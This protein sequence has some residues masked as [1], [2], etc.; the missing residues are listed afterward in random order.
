MSSKPANESAVP[1]AARRSLSLATRLTLWYASSAF[2]LVLVATLVLFWS[3]IRHL[4]H[5]DDQILLDRL[6]LLRTLAEADPLDED[7]LRAAVAATTSPLLGLPILVRVSTE[8]KVLAETHGLTDQIP[9]AELQPRLNQLLSTPSTTNGIEF[10]TSQGRA[11]RLLLLRVPRVTQPRELLLLAALDRT[12]EEQLVERYRWSLVLVV[13]LAFVVCGIVGHQIARRSIRPLRNIIATAGSIGSTTLHERIT[14]SPL[15]AELADLADTFNDMLRRLEESFDRLSRFSADIAH[16]LRTPLSNLRG[17][18]EVALTKPRSPDEYR[19]VL[20]SSLDECQRLSRMIDSLL[21][22]ARAEHPATQLRRERLDI[23]HE[24]RLIAE[25]HEAAATEAGLTM[26]VDVPVSLFAELDRTL[27]QRA[28]GN[29]LSNAIAH[30]PQGGRITLAA[31]STASP[32]NTS[33]EVL[34]I[35]VTDTGCGISAEHLPHVFDRLY[36]VD[37]SRT[38]TTGGLGLG[39]A[40]V[41]S[42][43]VLHGGRVEIH[44]MVNHGTTVSLHLAFVTNDRAD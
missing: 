2:V 13:S 17:Q 28:I 6:Q 36:R 27:F 24:L 33:S 21:F 14:A 26:T 29:L 5:E 9:Q 31:H 37:H 25:F 42:I 8:N 32:E 4:D 41:Q 3:L 34:Q 20:G 1:H 11:F 43:A 12:H 35:Q 15:P 30:T 10:E 44:S 7:A 38:S 22:I 16:E 18:T 39:L 40:I 19:D 23:A